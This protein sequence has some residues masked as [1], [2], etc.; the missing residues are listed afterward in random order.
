MTSAGSTTSWIETTT[1][2]S[3]RRAELAPR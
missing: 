1:D 3:N 2:S